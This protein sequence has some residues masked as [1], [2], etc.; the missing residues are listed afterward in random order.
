MKEVK[1]SDIIKIVDKYSGFVNSLC[2]RYFLIG[3]T[4]EDLYEEGIIGI[5]EAIRNFKGESLFS[6]EFDIFVKLCVKRQVIDAIKKS[7]TKKSKVLNEAVALEITLESGEE[8]NIL[9]TFQDP[10]TS[11]DPLDLILDSEK[12]NE[13]LE[14]CKKKLSKLEIEV[15]NQYLSGKKQSEIAESLNKT[16]KSIDDTIQ[17]IKGKMK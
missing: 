7:N 4:H 17:R 9:E 10:T 14:K 2:R 3:G 16:T 12:F 11:N 5:L 13:N 6:E 1:S 8:R 15:L